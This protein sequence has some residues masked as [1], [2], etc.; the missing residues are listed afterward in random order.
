MT[1]S[2][3]KQMFGSFLQNVPPMSE[4]S[5]VVAVPPKPNALADMLKSGNI[6]PEP[7]RLY[8]ELNSILGLNPWA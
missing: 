5:P 7:N 1:S 4:V 3:R 6:R 8:P 2:S